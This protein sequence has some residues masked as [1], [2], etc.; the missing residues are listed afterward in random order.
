MKQSPSQI[1]IRYQM[2][3][4][5]K[6]KIPIELIKYIINDFISIDY[7]I[8]YYSSF[9]KRDIEVIIN[10]CFTI[11]FGNKIN[12]KI[13]PI[14]NV[15]NK[16]HPLYYRHFLTN[17][18]NLNIISYYFCNFCEIPLKVNPSMKYIYP[19]CD[20]SY[21]Y[22]SIYTLIYNSTNAIYDNIHLPLFLTLYKIINAFDKNYDFTVNLDDIFDWRNGTDII[23]SSLHW[24]TLY[25][26][27]HTHYSFKK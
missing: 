4:L 14:D 16:Y 2:I 11:F 6:T 22:N 1:L 13:I 17:P 19:K 18:N 15:I 8:N 5:K 25:N 23:K 21:V 3:L 24:S 9:A 10:R 26:R 27:N 12:K 20:I 7:I